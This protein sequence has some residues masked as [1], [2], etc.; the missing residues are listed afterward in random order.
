MTALGQFREV[1]E[2]VDTAR[3]LLERPSIDTLRAVASELEKAIT[4]AG[5]SRHHHPTPRELAR[6]RHSLD[7]L[8]ALI[9]QGSQF[10]GALASLL[11]PPGDAY[12]REGNSAAQ[13]PP[14]GVVVEG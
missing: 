10:N 6:F 2:S 5:S 1:Q 9:E 4:A 12:T 13:A 11:M 3:R 8:G 7:T 14:A